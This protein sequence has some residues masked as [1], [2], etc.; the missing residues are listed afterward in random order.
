MSAAMSE[1]P[2]PAVAAAPAPAQVGDAPVQ[3]VL[4]DFLS[5]EGVSAETQVHLVLLNYVLPPQ[6]LHVW[7]QGARFA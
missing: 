7:H 3:L 1:A 5:Q 6:L 2:A 4:S